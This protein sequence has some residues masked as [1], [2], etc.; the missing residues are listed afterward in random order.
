MFSSIIPIRPIVL[1]RPIV[2]LFANKLY[3][4]C[5]YVLVYILLKRNADVGALAA[6]VLGYFH[7]QYLI[8][9]EM[10]KRYRS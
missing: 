7:V 1:P 10:R 3:L 2:V 4:M 8:G 9:V 5:T 6:I